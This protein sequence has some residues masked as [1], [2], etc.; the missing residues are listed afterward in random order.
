[1]VQITSSTGVVSGIDYGT[2]IDKLIKA[3][4]TIST[5]ITTE[6]TTL[7]NKQTAITALMADLTSLKAVTDALGKDTLFDTTTA[8]SSNTDVISVTT[9]G[10]PTTGTYTYTAL[11]K[12]LAQ[13]SISSSY[14]AT[15]S[16][17]GQGTLSLR[18]G[19][20]VDTGMSLSDINGGKGFT[21]GKIKITD[22]SGT[23]AV[24]DLTGAKTIDDV[25]DAINNNGTVDVTASVSGDSIVLTD[26]TGA[27][28]SNLKVSEVNSGKTAASLGI[29]G[30]SSTSTLTGSDI[31]YLSKDLSLDALNDGIG[32]ETTGSSSLEDISYT[33]SNG[34]TSK[35]SLAGATTL[36][37]VIDKINASST[38][39][40][41]TASIS[42]DGSHLILTDSS[43][44]TDYAFTVTAKN[45]SKALEDLFGITDTGTGVEGVITGSRIISGA[46]TV[47]L[48]DLNGGN[49]LGTLGT[50]TITDR[51]G[52]SADVGLS[53]AE[54]LQDVIDAINNAASAATPKVKITAQVNDAGNGIELVDSSGVTTYNLKVEDYDDGATVTKLFGGAVDVA[55]DSVNS[56]DLHLQTLGLNTKLSDLNGGS[57]AAQGSFTI[58][59]SNGKSA[60]ITIDDSTTTIGNVVKAI[61]SSSLSTGV[62]A[63]INDTGDGIKITD[64]AGGSGT[65]SVAEGDSTAAADLN[66]LQTATA[67]DSSQVIDG[68]MTRIINISSAETL[69]ELSDAINNLNAGVTASIVS[70]GT[71][72]YRLEITSDKT[73]AQ[74]K[75][76]LD[77]SQSDIA[78]DQIADAQDA[79]LVVGSTS[80]SSKAVVFNSSSNNFTGVLKGVTLTIEAASSSPVTVKVASDTTN[81]VSEI[82][83]FVDNYNTFRKALNTD[84]AYN[85]DT[86]TEAI[87]GNEYSAREADAIT[88]K[89]LSNQYSSNDTI[90]SLAQLG[91]SVNSTDGT[92]TLDENTLGSVLK[93][94]LSDVKELF[95]TADTGIADMFSAALENLAGGTNS[96]MQLKKTALQTIIDRNKQKIDDWTT[97]LDAERTRLTKQFANLET[98]ISKMQ[99]NLSALNS[100]SWIT[101]TSSSNSSSSSLYFGNSSSS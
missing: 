37:D 56:G 43:K 93:T 66:L 28:A 27:I 64:N 74:G 100:I 75:F 7:T 78:F 90:K 92:L 81:L 89:L 101:D 82:K 31:V 19:N 68:S 32:V 69:Q 38:S 45:G 44:G 8:T 39:K 65:L 77:A 50:I 96:L 55:N 30:T 94:N 23:S 86:K 48:S 4:S 52:N 18:F 22:R 67:K 63:E 60:T 57:G 98:F 58:T 11:E 83:S 72:E 54:T 33:L 91:I 20:G 12:A 71:S 6:N 16:T 88:S 84:T 35:I 3:D 62:L 97:R 2:L 79:V 42:S 17:V 10:T 41:L 95:T 47:L 70:D 99:N 5:A 80:S 15:S 13:Q 24:V 9:T 61:N 73:G 34:D 46:K 40:Y 51:A 26:N 53:N 76:I 29:L 25:L 49:G 85:T 14:A 21:S 59:D 1:M 87:L 36:G